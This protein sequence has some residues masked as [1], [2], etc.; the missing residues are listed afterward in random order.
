MTLN[1]SQYI[2]VLQ[3]TCQ[4]APTSSIRHGG[5][6]LKGQWWWVFGVLTVVAAFSSSCGEVGEALWCLWWGGWSGWSVC[7]MEVECRLL[8]EFLGRR[9]GRMKDVALWFVYGEGW[10]TQFERSFGGRCSWGCLHVW[11][12]ACMLAWRRGRVSWSKLK[13][14]NGIEDL[15]HSPHNASCPIYPQ[16][17]RE[18]LTETNTHKITACGPLYVCICLEERGF[19]QNRNTL[20]P[21]FY[22]TRPESPGHPSCSTSM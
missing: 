4:S 17:M 2:L 10:N 11:S 13:Q 7:D 1:G 3:A 18:G 16:D 8:W 9:G 20:P 19:L 21:P 14:M 22:Q 5:R 12:L 6:F 15:T